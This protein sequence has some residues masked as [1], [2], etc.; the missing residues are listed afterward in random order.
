[1]TS[2]ALHST[3]QCTA[4]LMSCIRSPCTYYIVQ[5]RTVCCNAPYSSAAY[6]G[7]LQWSV[8]NGRMFQ[9]QTGGGEGRGAGTSLCPLDDRGDDHWP[10]DGRDEDHSHLSAWFFRIG[11]GYVTNGPSMSNYNYVCFSLEPFSLRPYQ[12]RSLEKGCSIYLRNPVLTGTCIDRPQNTLDILH[13]RHF[14]QVN[15][16]VES[17]SCDVGLCVCLLPLPP[18]GF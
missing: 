18:L 9:F 16:Q 4:D 15:Q 13:N 6:G 14:T 7:P 10:L 17:K 3:V 2:T 5:Y 1:M 8:E 11:V 12:F